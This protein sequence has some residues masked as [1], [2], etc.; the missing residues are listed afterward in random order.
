MK[1]V[2]QAA[3]T[4]QSTMRRKAAKEKVNDLRNER[5]AATK[6]QSL[7]RSRMARRDVQN[8]KLNAQQKDREL[9]AM[10]AELAQLRA[11]VAQAGLTDPTQANV[12]VA[13]AL[14]DQ[15]NAAP[16]G[17]VEKEPVAKKGVRVAAQG[18][19]TCEVLELMRG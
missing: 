14:G 13:P 17:V 3:T 15:S 2:K 19:Y 5:T 10:S 9:N 7:Q 4:L 8:R 12:A 6:V 18:P 11:Q 16:T 1:E